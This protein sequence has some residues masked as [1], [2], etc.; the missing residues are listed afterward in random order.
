MAASHR[1]PGYNF[2][3]LVLDLDRFKVI[4]DSLGHGVG[5]GLLIGTARRLET[6]TRNAD[7]VAR[8]GGDEFAILADDIG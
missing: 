1:R 4:I 7:T 3:V 6:C 2:A 5:D 8:L